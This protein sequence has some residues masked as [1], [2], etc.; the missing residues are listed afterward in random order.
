MPKS[1]LLLDVMDIQIG[2]ASQG[3][4]SGLAFRLFL[5][6]K[7]MVAFALTEDQANGFA[8]EIESRLAEL[9]KAS[10]TPSRH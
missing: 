9:R 10:P 7:S 6:D 1:E 3:A 2:I 8:K 5:R 4:L